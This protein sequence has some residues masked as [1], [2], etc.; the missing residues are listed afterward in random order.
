MNWKYLALV[1]VL[2]AAVL[3]TAFAWLDPPTA[4][5]KAYFKDSLKNMSEKEFAGYGACL[6]SKDL[7][8]SVYIYTRKTLSE[9]DWTAVF[10]D[11]FD[12]GASTWTE[13]YDYVLGV[14]AENDYYET[15]GYFNLNNG[16]YWMEEISLSDDEVSAGINSTAGV[17][18]TVSLK[19]AFWS[20]WT[21]E[22]T[23]GEE[24]C[25]LVILEF[26]E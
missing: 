26:K 14:I 9:E 15:F 6:G 20:F 22:A 19:P 3:G 12:S 2:I 8:A 17:T 25:K 23:V 24:M 10:K 16:T 1:L 5:E 7:S 11:A 21:G 18:G 4:S 13:V